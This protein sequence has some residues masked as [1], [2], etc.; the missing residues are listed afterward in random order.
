[1]LSCSHREIFLKYHSFAGAEWKRDDGAVFKVEIGDNSQVCDATIEIRSDNTYSFSNIW[2]F[3]DCKSPD[4]SIHTDTV[5]ADLAD[6]KGKWFGKGLSLHNLSIPYKQNLFFP[7][8]GTYIYSIR[9]GMQ[10]NPLR[11]ITDI[12]LKI[13]E[14]S[15]K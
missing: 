2:L 1:M 10:D 7:N 3:V 6:V 12:A 14:K 9:Q 13:S 11:G 8:T 5:G 4:G 15:G